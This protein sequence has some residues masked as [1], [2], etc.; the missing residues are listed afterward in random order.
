MTTEEFVKQLNN[1][2]EYEINKNVYSHPNDF[3]YRNILVLQR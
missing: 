1:K 2:E 3:I